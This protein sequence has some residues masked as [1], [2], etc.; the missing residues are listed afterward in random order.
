[1]RNCKEQPTVSIFP[2]PTTNVFN[3]KY[4][5][6]TSEIS[7][8]EILNVLGQKVMSFSGFKASVDLAHLNNGIYFVTIKADSKTIVEK[9]VLER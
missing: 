1:M 4:S 7:S 5:G 2:N 6:E 8:V 3:L 9:I